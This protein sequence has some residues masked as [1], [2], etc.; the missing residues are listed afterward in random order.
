MSDKISVI[1]PYYKKIDFIDKTLKSV[2]SQNYKN[3][4]IIIIYDDPSKIDLKILKKKI[5]RKNVKLLI[6]EKNMGAGQSRNKGALKAKGRY[7][8]FLD[9]DDIW[10]KNKLKTQLNFMKKNNYKFSFTTYSILNYQNKV[11]GE[12]KAKKELTYNDLIKSCDIGLSTVILE[13]KIFLKYLF[14]KNKTKEDYSLWLRLSKDICINGLDKNLVK[15]RK[16]ENSLSSDVFQK[17]KDAFLIYF[18]QEKQGIFR[19]F[20]SVINL[21]INYLIKNNIAK[22]RKKIN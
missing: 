19:S 9:A 6:N 7:L 18:F 12:I 5:K 13:K 16:V 11:I 3:F 22:K 17:F 14:S 1:I 20:I 21:S 8:A 4:E 2:Y 10:E 15:W